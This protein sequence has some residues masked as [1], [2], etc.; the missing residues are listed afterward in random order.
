[1]LFPF[2]NFS[3]KSFLEIFPLKENLIIQF[4]INP[5]LLKKISIYV[6]KVKSQLKL[7]LQKS[8]L[9]SCLEMVIKRFF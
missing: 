7:L 5:F 1:M 6:V 4:W 2:F 9:F 3:F 8:S